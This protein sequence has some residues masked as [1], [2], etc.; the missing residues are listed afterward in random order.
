[1]Q[2]LISKGR[3]WL[4]T[5]A[6]A[7]IVCS[8]SP[9][10]AQIDSSHFEQPTDQLP[11]STIP[12]MVIQGAEQSDPVIPGSFDGDLRDL[13]RAPTRQP[14]DPIIEIP[15]Q[16]YP[17]DRDL[18]GS[19]MPP[20]PGTL[21]PLLEVQDNAP[22]RD[23]SRVFTTPMLN[24][25]GQSFTGV[26]PPDTVGDVGPNHYIQMV[27]NSGSSIFR[28]YNKSGTLLVGPAELDSLWTAGG[29]CATGAGD[30]IVLYDPLANRWLMSEFADRNLGNQLCVYISKTADPVTGGWWLYDFPTPNF[31]DYPKYAV[32]PDGYYVSTNEATGPAV[33]ALDRTQMI[34]GAAATLQR[35]TAP[36]LPAFG[37]QALIPGDLDGATPP[38]AGSP[39]YFMRHRDTEANND[40]PNAQ[41][42]LELWSF[43]V[44][45]SKPANSMFTGPFNIQVSEFDSDL[46]GLSSFFCFAQPG[47][48]Q[49]LD[50]LREVIMWRLQYRN[51]DN[52]ETLV[53]NFVTDVNGMDQGGIRWFELRKSGAGNWTLFQEGTYAPDLVN[54]WMGSIAMDQAGNI[55]L[56]YSASSSAVFPS[57][58]YTG[59]LAGDALG[60]M[61]QGETTLIAG[62]GSQTF[63]DRWGDYS[64]M[65]VDPADD[66]TFWYTNEYMPSNGQWNTRIGAF[67]FPAC[68][69]V[70]PPPPSDKEPD[71]IGV[72]RGANWFLD[73][74][75]NGAWDAGTDLT[76]TFGIATDQP[77][78]GDWNGDGNTE[79]GVKR[80]ANWFLDLNGNGAWDAGTDL[81]Y[82]FGID[83][84]QPV[85]GDWNDDGITEIGVKRGANWFLDLNGNGMLDSCDID[86][87]Y[88]FGIPMDDSVSGR[89]AP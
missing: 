21:D 87:C 10:S 12:P 79:I 55:A 63:A 40:P 34:S 20:L 62:N 82:A 57:I 59:R 80:G 24:F 28:I 7:A 30:P 5:L 35:F 45:W 58:R 86:D 11:L 42:I 15:R 74:N 67:K 50:P 14:G 6:S 38:P 75:G 49:T 69:E 23:A 41:D 13:P 64:A 78:T 33:Y 81:T 47:T 3:P 43:K 66:C 72:K 65:S 68:G 52:Y 25:E 1:M 2:V 60:T 44:D 26:V 19:V 46:C 31:P 76:Y 71:N 51:F 54:R 27:N 89:W 39:N 88:T 16:V 48:M 85:T 9:I 84:D 29:N 70:E 4:I 18:E 73:L 61:S 83:S 36:G 53:G 77:V 17:R 32:W 37:F 22:E 56:G 8:A